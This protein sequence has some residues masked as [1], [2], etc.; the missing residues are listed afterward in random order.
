MKSFLAL[1]SICLFTVACSSNPQKTSSV[2]VVEDSSACTPLGTVKGNNVLS[3]TSDSSAVDDALRQAKDAARNLG[4]NAIKI[5][6][7]LSVGSGTVVTAE[8]LQCP[9]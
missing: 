2:R 9:E 7:I 3:S 5:G 6:E 1:T 4:G 8:A